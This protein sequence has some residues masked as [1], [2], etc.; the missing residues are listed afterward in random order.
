MK[1]I[2]NAKFKEPSEI[3]ER[4][5]P[6]AMQKR[7]IIGGS[8]TGSG[9]TL[10]FGASI[11]DHTIKGKG[12]QALILTPTRELAEQVGNVIK[13]F[14]R[15]KNLDISIVYGG[16]GIGP[17]I[18]SLQRSEIV[19]GTPGRI[20]DHLQRG[21]INISK[22]K[23]LVLDE[24][25]RML[26]M[27]FIED[28]E[29]IISQCPKQ[30]Q[31]MLFSATISRDIEHIAH[32]HMQNPEYVAVES[33]VDPS[34]LKQIYYDVSSD[35]KFSL[36]LNLLKLERSGLVMVFCNTQRNTDFIA[37]NLRK[38]GVDATAIHGGLSQA[39]RNKIMERFHA[40]KAE[41]LICTDVAARGLDIKGVS[42]VY[43]Y[44]IPPSSKEYIH[45]IGRTARAGK[46]GIAISIVSQRDYDNFRS[47]L[48]NP[49][50][51]IAQEKMPDVERVNIRF[52]SDR[53]DNRDGQSRGGF[54]GRSNFGNKQNFGRNSSRIGQSGVRR[55]DGNRIHRGNRDFRR[56]N[57]F[58]NN[59]PNSESRGFRST[60]RRFGDGNGRFNVRGRTGGR[61]GFRRRF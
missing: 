61:T 53:S 47:V 52:V 44:D 40:G 15:F 51:K 26:D 5:I 56:D 41:V 58:S 12:I 2:D 49:D 21:T 8:A 17:Q 43:N 57:G 4:T 50:L 23:T 9:K 46:D 6:L 54:R 33:Y 48:R 36:L 7:D 37:A 10:A 27:G 16:V 22:I 35:L 38:F 18:N 42:H 39:K 3:Q 19:V 11:I 30:R 59:R 1:E 14:S 55:F 25:D 13:K 28:V 34:L 20:L 29:K 24:A 60:G 31:T 45:R 32:K